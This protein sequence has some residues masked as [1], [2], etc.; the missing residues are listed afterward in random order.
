VSQLKEQI[1][2]K[3]HFPKSEILL[4]IK[5]ED[6]KFN[7]L[8]TLSDE[9]PLYYFF[10]Y[11]NSEIYLEHYE[12]IDRTKEICEKIKNSKNKK[13]RHLKRLQIFSDNQNLNSKKNLSTIKESDNEY[14]EIDSNNDELNN[15]IIKQAIQFI[16]EDKIIP[17]KEYIYINEFIQED[18]SVL[19]TKENGWNALHYSCFYGREEMTETL[20][21]LFNPSV[22][23]I[24]GLTHD[25]YTFSL[26]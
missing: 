21:K 26:Y 16:I 17:L 25:G 12:K 3:F 20:I 1:S 5:Y 14:T 24:N 4:T 6:K 9:F 2:T 10:I 13:L 11:N 8:I 15:K 19:T 22:E 18:M 23:L 7:K